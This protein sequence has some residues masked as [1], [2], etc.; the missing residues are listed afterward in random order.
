MNDDKKNN[1]QIK[2]AV[3]EAL[4]IDVDKGIA[5]IPDDI[6]NKFGINAGDII[7]IQGKSKA[8]AT[9]WRGRPEDDEQ[10]IIRM[11]GI[12]RFTAGT[13]IGEDVT[14]SVAKWNEAKSVTLSPLQEVRFSDDPT[15]YFHNKLIDR[16]LIKNQKIAVDVMGTQLYYMITSVSPANKIIKITHETKINI[17]SKTVKDTPT[18]IPEITYE[19]IGGLQKETEMI[20]EM[21][22]TP[23]RYPEV[24]R[25]LGIG[26]PKGVL[27]SGP[28]GT[29]KTLLAKAVASETESNFYSIAGPELL[30]KYYGET[31]RQLRDIFDEA[32][33]NAPS[34]IFI[35]EIDS[36]APKR[37][38]IKGELEKRLV[39]QLLALM[40]GLNGRG[41]VVVMAAT[42]RP[43]DLDPALRRPGRFDRELKINPPDRQGRKEILQ[44]HSRSMPLADDVNLE[45]LSEKTLGYTGAD[46]EILCKEAAM[47]ALKPHMSEFKTFEDTVPTSLLEKMKVAMKNF[48]EALKMVEPSA[49]R[50]VLIQKPKVKWSDIGGLDDVKQK[51]KE[52]VEW[53]LKDPESF[54]KF[55]ITPAKGILLHGLPGTGKTLIAK[56]VANEADANFIA[57]KG[58]ELVSKWVG[59]SE[60]HVRDIFKKARQ[61]APSII[62]FDEFD[63]ISKVRGSCLTDS[64]ERMVNQLL[65][66]LDGIE[67]LEKVA[68]IA[69]TNRPELVDE[70]LLRPGRIGLKIETPIPDKQ[71]R[72]EIFKVHTRTM[73]L[74]KNINLGSWTDKTDGWTGADIAAICQEAGMDAMREFKSGKNKDAKVTEK[75]FS[76]AYETIKKN[77]SIDPL[78][79]EKPILAKYNTKIS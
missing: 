68:I 56:A 67:D 53:P 19:D 57:V 10:N 4:Q 29:G 44:I 61:V 42:N 63:S 30:N 26:A 75:H 50:E 71:S 5:R 73:P 64:T 13:S 23:M 72:V 15:S 51:I 6:M 79:I 46:L 40:D 45:K 78:N 49:M 52:A 36:I 55:G 12:I 16:P 74:D 76:H 37:E 58:P 25:R 60:K 69:A 41:Q 24:F 8:V 31:E 66:E 43:D 1:N 3:A 38:D 47:K 32:N 22:E 34:I 14:I 48:T 18:R 11:D 65:T 21:I 70:A 35:D 17:A 9:V 77:L 62:F 39:S 7:E 2:L 33:K 27:I 28:P 54:K 20:R 59:E